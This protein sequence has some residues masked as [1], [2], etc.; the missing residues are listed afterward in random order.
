[1]DRPPKVRGRKELTG[2]AIVPMRY[3]MPNI[4][5]QLHNNSLSLPD[6]GV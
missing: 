6:L 2:P 4:L 3:I 1:M 5:K